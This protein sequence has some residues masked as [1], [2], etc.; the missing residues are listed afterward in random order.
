MAIRSRKQAIAAASSQTRNTPGTCQLNTRNWFNAPA[1]GDR[2]GDGDADA[3]DGWKSEPTSRR[4][5]DDR[6]PPIGVPLAWKGGSKGFGHRAISDVNSIISTDMYNNRY[7]SGYTSHVR[8]GSISE[9]IGIIERSM[10][11]EYLG[12]SETITGLLIPDD[13]KV[14]MKPPVYIPKV[15]PTEGDLIVATN[16]VMSNPTNPDIRRTLE[17]TMP[18]P[19]SVVG[20]QEMDPVRYK[21]LAESLKG[22]DLVDIPD[23]H[24]FSNAILFK[25]SLWT[26]KSFDY[27]K[28]YDGAKGISYT[29]HFVIARLYHKILKVEVIFMSY[30]AVTKGTDRTRSEMRKEGL[31]AIR[32]RINRYK[33]EGVPIVVMADYNSTKPQHPS[34]SVTLRHGYDHIY[35]FD[36]KKAKFTSKSTAAVKTRSD[37]DAFVARL[38]LKVTR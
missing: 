11:V 30:H 10:G 13:T 17:S 37:H 21:D 8:A 36:G 4:H 14:V 28:Q 5:P 25:E 34:A 2:D 38:R 24:N 15:N 7:R 33:D 3:V 31:T 19:A 12:W 22:F 35:A 29:R 6:N 23:S 26:L 20:L 1:A 32:N 16:N 18:W 27:D 9:A